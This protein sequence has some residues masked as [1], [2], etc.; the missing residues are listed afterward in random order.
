MDEQTNDEKILNLKGKRIMLF[1]KGRGF[2]Y[3]GVVVD[4][5]SAF[6]VIN[7]DHKGS[8][9]VFNKNEISNLEVLR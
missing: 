5:T 7:D 1:L 3:S 6:V 4:E 9:R 2:R 8:T